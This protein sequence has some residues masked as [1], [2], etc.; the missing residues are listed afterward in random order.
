M[1]EAVLRPSFPEQ[2]LSFEEALRLYTI[3]AA[4][5]SNEET[6]KGSIEEGK[7]ADLTILSEDPF[8]VS[9]DKI[10]T[11]AIYMTIIDGKIVFS[12]Q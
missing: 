1:Q 8:N 12:R 9:P 2:R 5:C 11:V 4:Y 6:A 10:S 7:M 3:D